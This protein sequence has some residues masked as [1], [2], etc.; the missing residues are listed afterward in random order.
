M[1]SSQ[2]ARAQAAEGC[3]F[4]TAHGLDLEETEPLPDL[5]PDAGSTVI[6]HRWSRADRPSEVWLYE[7]EGGRHDWPGS[8]GNQDI[9]AQDEI[10]SF[11]ERTLYGDPSASR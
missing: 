8:Y 4:V 2:V 11:F 9:A 10:W 1:S 7:I 5:D 3:H 6:A